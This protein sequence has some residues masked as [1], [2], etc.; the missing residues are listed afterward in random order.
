MYMAKVSLGRNMRA[1]DR[2]RAVIHPRVRTSNI[3]IILWCKVG[4][5]QGDGW[6]GCVCCLQKRTGETEWR[7]LGVVW[8]A[9]LVDGVSK[10]W[11]TEKC[12]RVRYI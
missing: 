12:G 9:W 4:G 1:V 2:R 10:A 5:G 6:F 11:K 3:G 8:A 7:L